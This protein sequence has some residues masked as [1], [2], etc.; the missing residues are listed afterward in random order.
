M[1]INISSVFVLLLCLSMHEYYCNARGLGV[2]DKASSLQFIASEK[3]AKKAKLSMET[4]QGGETNGNNIDDKFQGGATTQKP[5]DSK[6]LAKDL[7][8]I[9]G[10]INPGLVPIKPLVSVS[11]RMPHKNHDE[12]SGFYSDYSRPRTRPPS[13]N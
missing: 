1:S 4:I 10:K 5:K 7:K 6:A 13:H 12:H 3:V 9:R 2:V 11:R 8:Y